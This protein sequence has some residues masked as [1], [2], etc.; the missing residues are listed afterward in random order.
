MMTAA[1]PDNF[2][3]K[4]SGVAAATRTGSA[5]ARIAELAAEEA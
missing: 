3:E 4:E 2:I 1:A 5:L